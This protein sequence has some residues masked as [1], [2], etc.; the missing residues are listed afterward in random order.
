MSA[1]SPANAFID[2]YNK[3]KIIPVSQD[4]TDL[5][6]FIFRRNYL[7]QTLGLPLARIKN[8]NVIE[9]GPG[10]GYN[11]VA[12]S[13]FG[14]DRYVFVDATAASIAELRKKEAAGRFQA[15][16]VEIVES[17]I[18]DYRDER[19]YDLVI[20]EGVIPGQNDP[21]RMIRHV[22]SFCEPGGLF[23]TTTTSAASILS[24]ICRRV[25]RPTI[26]TPDRTFAEQTRIGA[27]VFRSHLQNLATST[28]PVEDWVQDSILH[29]WQ[30]GKYV[31]TMIDAITALEDEFEFYSSS[32][33]FL[34]DDRWY[35]QVK[36]GSLSATDLLKQQYPVISAYFLDFRIP[37]RTV[38]QIRDT[39][40]LAAIEDLSK[41]A[42]AVHD[43]IVNENSY[44]RLE[45]FLAVLT[46][47][48]KTLPDEFAITKDALLNFSGA[49]RSYAAGEPKADF[50]SFEKWWGRGQQYLGLVRTAGGKVPPLAAQT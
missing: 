5:D 38:L 18:F 43:D 25:L 47:L 2:Y 30:D 15:R 32:P 26:M 17:N 49:S 40:R 28:R 42:C 22:A 9:F 50:R 35:K 4:L 41:S 10:G 11:A 13:R 44:N 12:T 19:G 29:D 27:D 48:T 34:F 16:N 14:P 24:E 8:L 39:A 33:R 23:F 37:L 1:T 21:R 45:D 3:N 20:C 36:P 31:F 7:Y 46:E 6:A